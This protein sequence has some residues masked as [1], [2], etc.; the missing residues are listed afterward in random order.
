[1]VEKLVTTGP[2]NGGYMQPIAG[3]FKERDMSGSAGGWS[4]T[5]WM[6]ASSRKSATVIDFDLQNERLEGQSPRDAILQGRRPRFRLLTTIIMAILSAPLML[7]TRTGSALHRPLEPA[8]VGG[9][10]VRQVLTLFGGSIIHLP[11]VAVH[12]SDRGPLSGLT[13]AEAIE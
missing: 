12:V 8:I 2:L 6:L 5:T 4:K 13:G 3:R 11:L 9:L 1:M 10:I 7:G